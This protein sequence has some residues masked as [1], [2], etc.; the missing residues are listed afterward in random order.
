MAPILL[1]S[2]KEDVRV[3]DV[4]FHE[5]PAENKYIQETI[6]FLRQGGIFKRTV[7]MGFSS[8]IVTMRLLPDDVTLVCDDEAQ[9]GMVTM[10]LSRIERINMTSLKSFEINTSN[11]KS[12]E[13][14][15]GSAQLQKQWVDALKEAVERAH[16]PGLKEQVEE[17]RRNREMQKSLNLH[18]VQKQEELE[19]KREL[20][21]QQAD[22][23][24]SKW[25]V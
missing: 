10:A 3:C 1:L 17:Q 15:A 18:E 16:K 21:R 4:C 22:K 5:I 25:G 8:K 20:R 11:G 12:R 19:H 2:I 13:F 7:M 9:G 14:E 24:K 23:L 6:P